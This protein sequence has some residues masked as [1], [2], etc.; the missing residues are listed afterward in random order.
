MLTMLFYSINIKPEF[1]YF[2]SVEIRHIHFFKPLTN[3]TLKLKTSFICLYQNGNGTY[4][5]LQT[6]NPH[7]H[8]ETQNQDELH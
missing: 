1:F 8:K 5:Q 3:K 7:H 4:Q 6:K 2:L